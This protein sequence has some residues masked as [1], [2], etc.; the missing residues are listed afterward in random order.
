MQ[1]ALFAT[2]ITFLTGILAAA[3]TMRMKRGRNVLDGLLT[4]PLVLPPTVIGFFLLLIFGRNGLVGG[5]LLKLEMTVIFTLTG[6]VIAAATVSF[7][8]MYRT[9][10]G[11]LES[12]DPDLINAAR[13]LGMPEWRIFLKVILPN[14]KSSI[15]AGTVLS[16]ARAMGEFGAT[17]MVAGNIPGRTQTMSTAVYTAVQSGNREAAFLWSA[18]ICLI[19]F[20]V[21]FILNR[22]QAGRLNHLAGGGGR[23][24]AG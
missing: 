18:L 10:R 21:V 6:A 11:A 5:L 19:S 17:I 24:F 14:I 15:L 13:T 7:P 4:L 22:Q 2:V 16:F 1:V 3:L 20:A 8:L 23:G 9:A 12:F